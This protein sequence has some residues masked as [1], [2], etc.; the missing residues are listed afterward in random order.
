MQFT[1]VFFDLD[2]TLYPA[3]SGLW[4]AIRQRISIYMHEFLGIPWDE[5]P[6]LRRK[7]FEEYGTALR[8]LET[9]YPIHREDY[10]AFVH[11]LPLTDYIHPD[12]ELISALKALPARKLIF[13]NADSAHARRVMNV[14]EVASFFDEIVDINDMEP[15]CK[16]MPES[17]QRAM[18]RA[19]ESDP[20]RCVLIDD[21]LRNIAGARTFGMRTVLFGDER[22]PP[23]ADASLV[24]WFELAEI[25]EHLEADPE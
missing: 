8:G 1:T 3:S 14:L 12:P 13:T 11:D 23:G 17:F 15:F 7:Y 4:E 16:P 24:N 2:D 25:L 19:G 9:H 18:I 5:I 21:M 6:D 22:H 20:H 10:L